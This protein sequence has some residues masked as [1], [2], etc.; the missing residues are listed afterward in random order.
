MYYLITA[1]DWGLS[2]GIN[3][4]IL[5]LV[6]T[7]IIK[8][9]SL[10]ATEPYVSY[11]LDELK[12][13][14]AE[15][16]LHFNLTLKNNLNPIGN[17]FNI[18]PQRWIFSGKKRLQLAF[19][20]LK[21]QI[22]S[23]HAVGVK[24]TYLDGHHHI[25]LIPGLLNIAAS[26]L[27]EIGITTV[28]IPYHPNMLVTSRAPI[29][30]LA[31]IARKSA[32]SHGFAILPFYYPSLKEMQDIE[33]LRSILVNNPQAEIIVH[34]AKSIDPHLLQTGDSYIEKRVEE[35]KALKRLG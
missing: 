4:G 24:P 8:R 32:K 18:S 7:G 17:N 19:E 23:L 10:M 9:V 11:R 20:C 5:E 27:K 12:K 35:Y 14:N 34:P 3:D 33:S 2:P 28:R 30:I 26:F 15:L 31:L 16:G 21:I 6:Q 25:H 22:E 29:A 13:T 1:D